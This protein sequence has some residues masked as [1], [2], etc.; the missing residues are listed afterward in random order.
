MLDI[1][2]N[3]PVFPNE[4]IEIEISEGA[5]IGSA[6]RLESATDADSAENGIR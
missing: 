1:N 3:S 6:Y 5:Q 4:N 2:D